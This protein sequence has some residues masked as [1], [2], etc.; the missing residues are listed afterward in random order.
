MNEKK[1]KADFSSWRNIT[2]ETAKFYFDEAEKRLQETIVT[3]KNISDSTHKII[4]VLISMFI[5]I[6]GFITTN[7][8]K[9]PSTDTTINFPLLFTSISVCLILIRALYLAIQIL[10]P[11]SIMTTGIMPKK[12]INPSPIDKHGKTELQ[13]ID[14]LLSACENYQVRIDL[15]IASNKQRTDKQLIIF[16][17]VTVWIP[18]ISIL[19][20]TVSYLSI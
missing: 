7:I 11:R 13:F 15:N 2:K 8:L 5:L 9:P 12:L 20:F 3:S 10:Q 1:F 6:F 4:T 16:K 18:S 19:I 14:I 17:L